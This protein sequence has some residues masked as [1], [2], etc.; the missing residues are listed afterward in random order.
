MPLTLFDFAKQP[1]FSICRWQPL[2][3]SHYTYEDARTTLKT[4]FQ[5]KR[6]PWASGYILHTSL[7]AYVDPSW[8]YLSI[9]G[10]RAGT[11][12]HCFHSKAKDIGM[13]MIGLFISPLLLSSKPPTAGFLCVPQADALQAL[14][15][16]QD[17]RAHDQHPHGPGTASN[18]RLGA[19][20]V[21]RRE[22]CL[23]RGASVVLN[24]CSFPFPA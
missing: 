1:P 4:I 20:A 11:L 3:S 16:V 7:Y 2:L 6:W 17:P 15:G 23:G 18:G 13:H 10:P 22:T 19:G 5:G 14:P 8:L 24:R 9:V 21:G 12:Q